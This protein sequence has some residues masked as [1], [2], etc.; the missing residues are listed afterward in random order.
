MTTLPDTRYVPS[1]PP[2]WFPDEYE[3]WNLARALFMHAARRHRQGAQHLLVG[4]ALLPIGGA[5]GALTSEPLL[6]WAL[7]VAGG[8]AMWYGHR[9]QRLSRQQWS[10]AIGGV[11]AR[12][13]HPAMGLWAD[14]VAKAR[15]LDE[16]RRERLASPSGSFDQLM[17]AVAEASLTGRMVRAPVHWWYGQRFQGFADGPYVGTVAKAAN[18]PPSPDPLS[19]E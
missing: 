10:M 15:L 3:F 9:Q 16:V 4:L 17:N 2:E 6:G 14:P 5:L 18:A 7:S 11:M 12:C 19:K 13:H 8:L 1:R